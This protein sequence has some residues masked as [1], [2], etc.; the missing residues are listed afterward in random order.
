MLAITERKGTLLSR[1]QSKPYEKQ[2]SSLEVEFQSFLRSTTSRDVCTATSDDVVNFLI[3]KDNFGKTTIHE[4]SC[5]FDI[6]DKS[7]CSCP[8]RLAYGTVDSYIG[9][10]RAI[11][12]KYGRSG[13][14][15]I[16]PGLGNPAAHASV[17]SYLKAIKE[18][19]L[20]ARVV[21][22]QAEPFFIH[23]LLLLSSEIKKRMRMPAISPS[24]LF[25]LGRDQAFFK[26]QFF[27]G[28]R[29]ADLGK[30][31]TR[32]MLYFPNKK[33]LLFNHTLTKSLREGS[34]NVFAV[35]PHEDCTVCP[36]TA[37]EVYLRLCDAMN[38]PIRQGYLFRPVNPSGEILPAPFDSGAAQARLS[39][40]TKHI[41]AFNDRH[42]TL[43]GLRSGCAISLA[44]SGVKLDNIMDHVGWKTTSTADHY[45]KF[46]QV[47]LPGGAAEALSKL[48]LDLTDTYKENN[49]LKDFTQV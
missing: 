35:K 19:Q 21:P 15:T 2:K 45:I 48:P 43:H 1:K 5:P 29:A 24:Q 31:K 13:S 8:K 28:D 42:I 12:H 37:I 32:E 25:I 6:R 46:C 47:L 44:L 41:A 27:G 36:V 30:T 22:S 9:K 40:Y 10:L 18:E 11:F 4:D 16:V 23:D 17:K 3:W 20:M 39:F 14:D 26:V 7:F 38:I 34:P 49:Q 33:G